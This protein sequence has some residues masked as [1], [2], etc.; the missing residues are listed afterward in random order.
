M[1]DASVTYRDFDRKKDFDALRT[2]F[3]HLQ[4]HERAVYR[5]LPAGIEVADDCIRHMLENCQKCDGRIIIA[6]V[7]GEVGGFITV[8][9]RVVSEEPDD[10][11]LEYALISDLF[12]HDHCRGKGIGRRLLQLAEDHARAS[13][14]EW[15]RVGVLSGNRPAETLYRSFGFAA[16]YVEHE[17][18][19]QA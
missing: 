18:P 2:C 9:N 4:D 13:G 11:K 15:L 10:G 1:T 12:V 14:A 16:W 8:L 7:D 19:L 6:D 3:S 17:K 5:R